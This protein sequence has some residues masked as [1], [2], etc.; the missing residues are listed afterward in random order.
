MSEIS[1]THPVVL[2]A[3]REFPIIDGHNDLP[4]ASR[5]DATAPYSVEGL[6]ENLH[7]R[8]RT[9]IP[10]LRQG[11]VGGQFWS[12]FVPSSLPEPEAVVATLEQID[13][14][15]R[16]VDRYPSDL[17]LATTANDVR[18]AWESGRIASLMGIEGGH[19]IGGSLGV[20][21]EFARRGVRYMTLTHNDN[22]RWADSAAA[23][24][25][26]NGLTEFGHDVIR[27]M[28][29]V[30]MIV[31]LSHVAETTMN[32]ALETTSKPVIFSHSSCF[33]QCNHPRNVPDDVLNKLARN[34]G[35]IMITFVPTFLSEE[36]SDWREAGRVGP[37]PE[38]TLQDVVR[39]IEHARDLIGID[40]I[41]L[42]GDFD[43]YEDFPPALQDVSTY[44][45]VLE[46][47]AEN[48]WSAAEIGRLTGGNL[49]RVLGDS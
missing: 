47:L 35:V 28:N 49:L 30:G 22:T 48:G 33:S 46:C 40:H 6:N 14:V 2:E 18:S 17:V 16:L 19:S 45:A 10:R 39:H 44:P 9:D 26:H 27:E 41:G 20:L 1:S 5:V 37:K 38:V 8:F 23:I 24:P 3:L 36:Y 13:Y 15:H 34:G 11:G 21:R 12:V 42:G 7:A 25:E 32:A 29:A 43:G 31:D 4:W